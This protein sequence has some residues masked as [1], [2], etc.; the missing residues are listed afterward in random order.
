VDFPAQ[1]GWVGLEKDVEGLRADASESPLRAP[2][3]PPRVGS[4]VTVK[5]G[6]TPS[7]GWGRITADSVGVVKSMSSESRCFVDFPEHK[8]W[9]GAVSE[10]VVVPDEAAAPVAA[11]PRVGAPQAAPRSDVHLY[12]VMIWHR[13]EEAGTL[14]D[15]FAT[16]LYAALESLGFSVV[17]GECAGDAAVSPLV[18]DAFPKCRALLA[19]SS[20]G[21]VV[22]DT[23]KWLISSHAAV[24][25]SGTVVPIVGVNHS[26]EFPPSS[27]GQLASFTGVSHVSGVDARSA[28]FDEV[29]QRIADALVAAGVKPRV[30]AAGAVSPF[31]SPA[32]PPAAAKVGASEATAAGA[33]DAKRAERLAKAEK[34]RKQMEVLAA[35]A[36]A[37]EMEETSSPRSPRA[38]RRDSSGPR[39]SK[40]DGKACVICMDAEKSVLLLPCRHL[41]VCVGCSQEPR[42]V[43]CPICREPIAEKMHVFS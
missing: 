5:R 13:V 29:V 16:M 25:A 27:L 30:S 26:G 20:P 41:C 9:Q 32:R 21:L 6:V 10:L 2:V 40:D 17:L 35:E 15:Q 14:G 22:D 4:R 28:P 38:L 1:R 24:E 39:A 19:L 42:L 37:L 8:N 36:K 34:L 11:A 3:G 23:S 12:D 7:L 31:S 33:V 43:Q 18:R